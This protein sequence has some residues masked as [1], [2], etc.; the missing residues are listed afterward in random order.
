MPEAGRQ[1]VVRRYSEQDVRMLAR[2]KTLLVQGFTYDHVARQLE[3]VDP[4][5]DGDLDQ[6]R[7]DYSLVKR[8]DDAET[9]PAV[10]LLSETLHTVSESQQAILNVQQSSRDLIG[11]V[12]Q[13]N[14]NLK[15]ENTKLRDRMLELERELSEIRRHSEQ[16]R[17]SLEDRLRV[18]ELQFASGQQSIASTEETSDNHHRPQYEQVPDESPDQQRRK[19][20]WSRIAGE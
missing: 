12:I 7:P 1:Q 3:T 5:A 16:E 11:V 10:S 2:V 14:F 9:H 8:Q 17:R 6:P 15:A 19:G 20:F 13:D 18:V 4:S